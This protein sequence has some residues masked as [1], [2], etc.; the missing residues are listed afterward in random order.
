[1]WVLAGP[2][3][4]ATT[5]AQIAGGRTLDAVVARRADV[6]GAAVT[7]VWPAALFPEFT[8][9]E[10]VVVAALGCCDAEM[11]H[12][13]PPFFAVW[14]HTAVTGC[15]DQVCDFVCHGRSHK[16]VG[17]ARRHRQVEAQQRCAAAHPHALTSGAAA[18]IEAYLGSR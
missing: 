13:R 5:A 1:M 16:A 8:L 4:A 6:V 17:L 15:R 7:V 12:D 11:T 2:Q 3:R 18:Q 10:C 14:S 9:V